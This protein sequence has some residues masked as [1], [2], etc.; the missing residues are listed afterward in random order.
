MTSK[1]C[2]L[3]LNFASDPTSV[4]PYEQHPYSCRV[5]HA[6]FETWMLRM[7]I[8]MIIRSAYDRVGSYATVWSYGISVIN[9]TAVMAQLAELWPQDR[10][11]V[12]SSPAE[13][14]PATDLFLYSIIR[15]I[16]RMIIYH[17]YDWSSPYDHTSYAAT[18]FHTENATAA[19]A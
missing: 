7:I 8:R 4:H 18:E 16:I 13:R 2:N 11:I 3:G 1:R 9:Q 14:H 15:M 6:L 10:W 19:A 5:V 12:G 17:T